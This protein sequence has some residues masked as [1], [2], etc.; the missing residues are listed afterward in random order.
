[1]TCLWFVAKKNKNFEQFKTFYTFVNFF[2][3]YWENLY[4]P[5][6]KE[7]DNYI[8]LRLCLDNY[9]FSYILT[10]KTI[11]FNTRHLQKKTLRLQFC[12]VVVQIWKYMYTN[13]YC[14]YSKPCET[15]NKTSIKYFGACQG[16]NSQLR[17]MSFLP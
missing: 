4:W 8:L 11:F 13:R 7:F 10:W 17:V 3:I 2:Q 15:S 6:S 16:L 9:C 5:F 1:M 12:I 14:K